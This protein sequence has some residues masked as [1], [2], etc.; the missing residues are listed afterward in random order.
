M[1]KYAVG[2]LVFLILISA[3]RLVLDALISQPR[4]TEIV[5]GAIRILIIGICVYIVAVPEGLP[6]AISISMALSINRLKED[7]ILIKNLQAVQNCG[8]L[9][10]ICVGKTGTLTRG[11]GMSV[12]KFHLFTHPECF[13]SGESDPDPNNE[14]FAACPNIDGLNMRKW[15]KDLLRDSILGNTNAWLFDSPKGDDGV[16]P[17]YEVRG[18]DLEVALLKY[19][20]DNDHDVHHLIAERNKSAKIDFY[21][22]WDQNHKVKIIGRRD[23]NGGEYIN[24]YVKGCPEYV[25]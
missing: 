5:M 12:A 18:S 20:V 9:H 15:C 16:G 1:A 4:G 13:P 24:V 21:I 8:L 23:P 2:A 19:L 6:L 17:K 22:P 7:S 3:I 25:V 10:D 14:K 11:K